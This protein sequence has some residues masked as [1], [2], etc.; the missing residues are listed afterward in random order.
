[1]I[2]NRKDYERNLN[3]LLEKMERREVTFS[4]QVAHSIKSLL[5]VR[6]APNGRYNFLTV[7]E[8]ARIT[9]NSIVMMT[10]NRRFLGEESDDD[11]K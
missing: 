1:M 4:P 8:H 7:D 11:G 2:N 3:I 10:Q 9:A 5:N 6:K